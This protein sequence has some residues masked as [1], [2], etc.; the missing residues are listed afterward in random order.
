MKYGGGARAGREYRK[1]GAGTK[2]HEKCEMTKLQQQHEET[3]R[4]HIIS[5]YRTQEHWDNYHD[6]HA[7]RDFRKQK[8]DKK[9]NLL[10][11]LG[12]LGYEGYARES[13]KIVAI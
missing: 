9:M 2:Q 1:A 11:V 13:H 8:R 4:I 3:R 7:A 12:V 6:R 10:S 5:R